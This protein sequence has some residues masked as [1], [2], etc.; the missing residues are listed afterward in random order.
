VRPARPC[1]LGNPRR[2]LT[3][4]LT[5][6]GLSALAI[7]SDRAGAVEA[8]LFRSVNRLPDR[9]AGPV[10]LIMQGGQLGAAPVVA[11]IAARTGRPILARRMLVSGAS[12]WALAKLV[13]QSVRR[14]RPA[15]LVPE[16]R[17]RGRE[18]PGLGF[19]SGHAAVAA[20]LCAAALPELSP[21]ARLAAITAAATVAAGRLY[22]GAHLPLDV[23]GG[24]ALGVAVEAAV[25]LHAAQRGG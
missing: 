7:H 20:S 6:F 22:V 13:K 19:V 10:W 8:D 12:T 18:Q 23:A 16:T 5:V 3:L 4:A 11:A 1:P 17:R 24:A 2:R 14:P 15:T 21:K 25:E 9:L